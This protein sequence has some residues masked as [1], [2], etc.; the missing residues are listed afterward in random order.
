MASHTTFYKIS[1][2]IQYHTNI[3][4]II[5]AKNIIHTQGYLTNHLKSNVKLSSRHPQ[6][7]HHCER[8]EPFFLLGTL[9]SKEKVSAPLL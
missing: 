4:N 1:Y 2:L 9:K 3:N 7:C 6:W 8:L 5:Q